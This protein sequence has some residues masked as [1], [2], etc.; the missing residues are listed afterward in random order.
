MYLS[1][2]NE[3]DYKGFSDDELD[4][5]GKERSKTAN[6][7]KSSS[8]VS[9]IESLESEESSGENEE[10]DETQ[11]TEDSKDESSDESYDASIEGLSK[12]G[13]DYKTLL[14]VSYKKGDNNMTIK[15]QPPLI[16]SLFE[17]VPPTINFITQDEK[18]KLLI[19]KYI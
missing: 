11:E 10:E 15:Y 17:F 18:R 12:Y 8:K 6:S 7:G 3:E 14:A 4:D 2:A 5:F 1:E 16:P 19:Q 13:Y 9:L